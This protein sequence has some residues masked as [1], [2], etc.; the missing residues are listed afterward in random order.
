M[1]KSTIADLVEKAFVNHV[2]Q[3]VNRFRLEAGSKTLGF[4]I[5]ATKKNL[6][7]YRVRLKQLRI[8]PDR[9]E[10]K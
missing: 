8:E 3:N 5:H 9:L 1:L 7:V 10:K 6:P 2:L 4:V